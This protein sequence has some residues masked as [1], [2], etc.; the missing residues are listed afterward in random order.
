MMPMHLRPITCRQCGLTHATHGDR[1]ARC[2]PVLILI[3]DV[4]TEAALRRITARR[5]DLTAE[6][7][8]RR[9]VIVQDRAE[10]GE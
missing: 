5:P 4:A 2:A 1:C 7:I 6:E 3:L 8:V 10:R 9:C